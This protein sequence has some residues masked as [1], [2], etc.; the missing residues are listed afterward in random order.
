VYQSSIYNSVTVQLESESSF[1]A[2]K[3]SLTTNPLLTVSVARERD[4]YGKQ[5]TRLNTVL[6]IVAYV[7]GGIMA[8]GAMFGALSTMYSAVSTR[9]SE[10]ATLRAIG[11]GASSVVVSVLLE[12]LLL[13]SLGGLAGGGLAW[14]VFNGRHITT[15]LGRGHIVAQLQVNGVLLGNAIVWACAIGLAG[16]LFP[17]IR[18]ARLPVATALRAS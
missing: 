5:S 15:F 17:A 6:T 12:S 2:F 11:F 13:A 8:V 14:F 3:D 4:Y 9:T 1:T 10:I 7:V 16:G 18:A